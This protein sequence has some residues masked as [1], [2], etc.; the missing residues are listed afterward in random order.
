MA[1]WGGGNVL[2][3]IGV[4]L[5]TRAHLRIDVFLEFCLFLGASMLLGILL[6][7]VV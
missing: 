1:A 3:E 2:L 7:E 4:F 6:I 5:K